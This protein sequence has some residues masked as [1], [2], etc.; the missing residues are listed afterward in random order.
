MSQ[1]KI[2]NKTI[3]RK[4]VNILFFILLLFFVFNTNAKSWLLQQLVSVGLFNAE[5]KE[6]KG[7]K[8]S[9]SQ[10]IP[11]LFTDVNGKT[12]STSDLKGKVVFVNFWATWCPPCLAEMPSL[13]ALYNKLKEDKRFIFLFIN[14]DEDHTKGEK[15]LQRNKFT[16]PLYI[17]SGSVPTEI[18]NGTLPTT[19][20]LDKAGNVVLKHEG[21]AGY[22]TEEFIQ[23][24]KD[25]L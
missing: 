2:L 19:I 24:L 20:V 18:F 22:N 11:F 25:L 4:T 21:M 16:I 17:R 12:L 10:N 6:E 13:N 5:I 15:Y 8:N 9:A 23:Q 7:V 1:K 14:E 3:L